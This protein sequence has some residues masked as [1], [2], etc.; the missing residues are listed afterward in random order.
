MK[1]YSH[2]ID[3][4]ETQPHTQT[5][6]DTY[7]PYLGEPWAKIA[8]GDASDVDAAVQAA[9][10]SFTGAPWSQLTAMQRGALLCRVGS[11]IARDAVERTGLRQ[12]LSTYRR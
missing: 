6:F 9:H 5:W 3:G 7:N 11:L 4:I 8:Q 10:R 2:Y 12:S 1:R